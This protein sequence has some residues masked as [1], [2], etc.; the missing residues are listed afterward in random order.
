[1]RIRTTD[2]QSVEGQGIDGRKYR[3]RFGTGW[4][5]IQELDSL[6]AIGMGLSERVF[7][8]KPWSWALNCLSAWR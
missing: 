7:A 5:G 3:M 1:M 2:E 8:I 6:D 4:E